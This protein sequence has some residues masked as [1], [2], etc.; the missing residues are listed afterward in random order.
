MSEVSKK[1]LGM[2]LIGISIIGFLLSVF[3]IYMVWHYRQPVTDKLRGSLAQTSSVL[4]TTREGLTVIDQ[5]VQNVYTSTVYLDDATTALGQTMVSTS[6]F[7]D[8][9]G[10][11]IGEDLI[12]TITNTQTA[13]NAAQSSAVVIDN[14]LSAMSKIPFIGINYNPTIPLNKALGEVSTS[15]DPVQSSLKDFQTNLGNTKLSIDGLNTQISTLDQ[16]I[17][18]INDNLLEARKTISSYSTQV[19]SLKA[20]VEGAETKLPRWITTLAWALSAVILWLVLIQVGVLIQGVTLLST[21][22]HEH[23]ASTEE[24]A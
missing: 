18:V 8:S 23:A 16:K 24:S 6:A 1:A 12:N 19:D 14:I 5:V 21:A 17:V 15:L 22:R 4:Q 11:F 3:F 13:L 7:M 20:S 2:V 10:T 9:A